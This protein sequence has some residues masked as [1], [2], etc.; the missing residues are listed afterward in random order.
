MKAAMRRLRPAGYA[1]IPWW[2][3]SRSR[4]RSLPW[5]GAVPRPASPLGPPASKV[6]GC[7]P[8][9]PLRTG[10]SSRG[11][12]WATCTSRRTCTDRPWPA[13]PRGL[14]PS[15]QSR[16]LWA[17]PPR[18]GVRR[19]LP[20]GL[21]PALIPDPCHG[22]VR[23]PGPLPPWGLLPAWWVAARHFHPCEQGLPVEDLRGLLALRAVHALIEHGQLGS[24]FDEHVK[25]LEIKHGD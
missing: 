7:T 5:T 25:G 11:S 24:P 4:P 18:R 12:A 14:T 19:Q 6:G 3:T 20:G 22:R 10:P 23:C 9:P 13:W 15:F 1:A 21:L 17:G 2:H 16:S 8:L